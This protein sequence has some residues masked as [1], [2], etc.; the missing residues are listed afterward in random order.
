MSLMS[1]LL[2][3]TLIV[4]SVLSANQIPDG[5]TLIKYVKRNIATNPQVKV[6]SVTVLET[7]T[8]KELPGWTILLTTMDLTFKKKEVHAPQIMFVKDGLITKSLISQ[9]TGN[10]YK[11]EI[12]PSVPDSMYNKEHLVFGSI[13]AN[14]KILV[15]SD[16]QCP[17]CQELIPEIF[18]VVKGN[19]SEV[20]MYYY[21]LPLLAIHP[22]SD[23]LTKIMHI[24]QEEGK[25]DMLEKIYKLKISSKET[26]L[27]KIIAEVKKQTGYVV[28]KEQINEKKVAEALTKDA[29]AAAKM[30]VTGTPTIYIDGEWDKMRNGHKKFEKSILSNIGL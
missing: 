25:Y 29:M 4:S 11:D 2:T 6:N 8:H 9:K 22:V 27:N 21:H 30:M 7:K 15:F 18:E 5:K 10:D 16:P 26:D 1:K 13:D 28:T 23:A 20:A 19:P 17:F 12:K 24:A 3:S 14:H